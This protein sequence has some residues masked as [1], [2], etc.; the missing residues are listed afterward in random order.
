MKNIQLEDIVNITAWLF[1]R[2]N[3]IHEFSNPAYTDDTLPEC[4]DEELWRKGDK[5]AVMKPGRKTALKVFDELAMAKEYIT[6]NNL[7]DCTV[8]HRKGAV[9]RCNPYCLVRKWC[10]QYQRLLEEGVIQDDHQ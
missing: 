4:T 9:A 1:E 2:V 8:E 7:N 10:N 3:L 5:Y 6:T